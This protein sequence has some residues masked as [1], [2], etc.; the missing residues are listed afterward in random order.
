MQHDVLGSYPLD[1]SKEE[2]ELAAKL[3]WSLSAMMILLTVPFVFPLICQILIK[4][5]LFP[6]D[7]YYYDGKCTF[8]VIEANNLI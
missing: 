8:S 6:V 7:L 2:F 5:V 1:A 4:L 3:N